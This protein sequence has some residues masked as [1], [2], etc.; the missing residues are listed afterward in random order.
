M[1]LLCLLTVLVC[2]CGGAQPPP[3]RLVVEAASPA[4]DNG[5]LVEAV[6]LETLGGVFTPLLDASCALPCESTKVFS[7]AEDDQ[8]EIS[9]TLFRGRG[10]RVAENFRLGRFVIRGIPPSPRGQPQIAVTVQAAAD[11][12][13]LVA[14]DLAKGRVTLS[15]AAE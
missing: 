6:G 9:I 3:S 2:G 14:R 8:T 7:T 4:I 12:V 1:R 15:L 13:V 10:A 11:D 5:R